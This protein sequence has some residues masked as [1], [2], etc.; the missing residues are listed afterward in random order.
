MTKKMNLIVVPVLILMLFM[1]QAVIMAANAA[2]QPDPK[3][4]KKITKLM[5][6]GDEKAKKNEFDK[7][8]ELYNK[9]LE[10]S[11][12]YAPVYLSMARVYEKQKK[13]DT[14]IENLEKAV[15]IQ[16]DFTDAIRMLTK[17]LIGM[18]KQAASRKQLEKSNQYYLK[19]LEIPGIKNAA[20][21]QLIEAIFQLGFNYPRLNN[22][23]RS[24]EYLFKLLAFPGLETSDKGKFVKAS[25]QIGVNYFKLKEF[26]KAEEYLSKLVK[27]D[28]LKTNFL[29]VYTISHY[30][31]GLNAR[32]LENYKKS[33]AYFSEYL[34]VTQ[35]NP[36]DQFRPAVNF[37]L[38]SNNYNLL[39]KKVEAIKSEK[40]EDMRKRVAALAKETKNIQPYLS[41]AI[42]LNPSLEPA[43]L[44]LGNYYFLCQDYENAMQLYN[45][46][47]EKFP[48]SQDIETYK[49]FL[50]DIEKESK[51]EK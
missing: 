13:F 51:Q 18:G 27:V 38:G 33:N 46:L 35:N 7:A 48:D 31:A 12:E 32:Q 44:I 29:Q 42:E 4:L 5:K 36:S 9:V 15:D 8:F 24:N 50:K 1:F 39:Q 26:E 2:D 45:R 34:E 25:Y 43:Y 20:N 10:L 22:P 6:K 17:N 28:G 40:K 49:R 14:A 11:T 3:T 30:L 19:V 21:D 23:T 41:K 37:M 47:I 16:P